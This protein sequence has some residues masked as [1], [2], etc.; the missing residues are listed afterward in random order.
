MAG[1]DL[2]GQFEKISDRAWAAA[3]NLKD[4]QQRTRERLEFD[5]DFA[6]DRATTAADRVRDDVAAA[7]DRASSQWREVREKW[8]AHVANVRGRIR[9]KKG[10]L[11]ADV[12]ERDANRAEDYALDTIAFA[13]AAVDEAESAVLGAM[14]ARANADALRSASGESG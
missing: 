14:Y 13:T 1:I 11:D 5:V 7:G 12:A 3:D 4:A 8:A 10:H 9:E 2:G 6:R